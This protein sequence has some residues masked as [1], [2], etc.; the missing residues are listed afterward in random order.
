MAANAVLLSSADGTIE[1]TLPSGAND[2]WVV[3]PYWRLYDNLKA[4][5]DHPDTRVVVGPGEPSRT[6][7]PPLLLPQGSRA[8]RV[9]GDED[10]LGVDRGRRGMGGPAHRGDPAQVVRRRR[11]DRLEVK[12]AVADVYDD[13]P[14]GDSL[15]E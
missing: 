6:G 10:P 9:P 1:P 13:R 8:A 4:I 5:L 3:T 11:D 7:R 15:P 12:V 2:A 14:V